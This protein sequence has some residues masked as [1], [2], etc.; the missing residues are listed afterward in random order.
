ME[1]FSSNVLYAVA[2]YKSTSSN[3]TN[4]EKKYHTFFSSLLYPGKDLPPQTLDLLLFVG[5]LTKSS[6]PSAY[7]RP[8]SG[9]APRLS[10]KSGVSLKSPL[11][12]V[13]SNASIRKSRTAHA[14]DNWLLPYN[15]HA[16]SSACQAAPRPPLLACNYRF[17]TEGSVF[18][19]KEVLNSVAA[20][21]FRF[22]A[23]NCAASAHL[24]HMYRRT[25]PCW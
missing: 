19:V 9:R 5:I 1:Y 20:L 23:I 7:R 2:F 15:G 8:S 6:R 12:L 14:D 24:C 18:R 21:E 11:L 10:I 16:F 4:Q 3:H 13:Y 22:S 17:A 25:T